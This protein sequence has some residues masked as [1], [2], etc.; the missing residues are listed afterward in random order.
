[1]VHLFF[2]LVKFRLQNPDD[3]PL[4]K[5]VL[6]PEA[7]GSESIDRQAQKEESTVHL[8]DPKVMASGR[9]RAEVGLEDAP[10]KREK[11]ESIVV[12]QA[13]DGSTRRSRITL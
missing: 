6:Y 2:G 3:L 4:N 11:A 1:M 13:F 12:N 9:Q 7:A 10:G 8:T 5:R